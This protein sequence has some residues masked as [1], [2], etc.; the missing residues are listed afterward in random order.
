MDSSN[1]YNRI[2][3]VDDD[4]R[5]VALLIQILNNAGFNAVGAISARDARNKLDNV[6]VIVIDCMMPGESGID[7]VKSLRE[8]MN[9]TPVI[10]LTAI[11]SVDN[12]VLGFENGID[13]Y[14]TKP[15]DER[16]LIARLKRITSKNT[17]NY[18]IQFGDC[19]FNKKTG[20]LT[21][22]DKNIHLSSTELSLLYELL[23]TPNKAVK[24]SDLATK[25]KP[26]VSERTID[27]QVTRLRKKIGDNP[28]MPNIIQTVRHIG[29]IL[30]VKNNKK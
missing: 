24:R 13:D 20:E 1:N 3:I 15:F 4:Q 11:D 29:Y 10:L 5:I 26:L 27:V 25:L 12:K 23:K 19:I 18:F 30:I 2:L 17:D 7:F 9:D 6:D 14:I 21:K 22:G 16:E 8:Q 28:K